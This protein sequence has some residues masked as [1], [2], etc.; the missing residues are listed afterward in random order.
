MGDEKQVSKKVPTGEEI[1][2]VIMGQPVPENPDER[3][4]VL[5]A[6]I[7]LPSFI[8]DSVTKKFTDVKYK[9]MH[10]VYTG[11]NQTFKDRYKKDSA[12]TVDQLCDEGYIIKRGARGGPVLYLNG[13]Q[14]G[15]DSKDAAPSNNTKSTLTKMGL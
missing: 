2:K 12:P 10:V 4:F 6:I 9:A 14:P 15:G 5:R 7:T 8:K 1:R 3:W 13:E 11:F